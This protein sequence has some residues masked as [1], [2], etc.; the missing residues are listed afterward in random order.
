MSGRYAV[1][2]TGSRIVSTSSRPSTH[3]PTASTNGRSPDRRAVQVRA[4]ALAAVHESPHA[5]VVG[6]TPTHLRMLARAARAQGRAGLPNL[7]PPAPIARALDDDC[8]WRPFGRGSHGPCAVP[9][10]LR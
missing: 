1:T 4:H 10:R 8:P 9:R 5:P 3:R 6:R 7:R 2:L